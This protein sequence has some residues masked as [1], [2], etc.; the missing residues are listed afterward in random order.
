MTGNQ[1]PCAP[2]QEFYT[3]NARFCTHYLLDAP[4]LIRATYR[5]NGDG[6]LNGSRNSRNDMLNIF[7]R[8]SSKFSIR[9]REFS[10]RLAGALVCLLIAGRAHSS[11]GQTLSDQV[12]DRVNRLRAI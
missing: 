10:I 6:Y 7:V 9:W 4:L 11:A 2:E 8:R 3:R 1:F 5:G 12:L